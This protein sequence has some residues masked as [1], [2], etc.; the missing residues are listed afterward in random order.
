LG[1]IQLDE[2][3]LVACTALEIAVSPICGAGYPC[4]N[5]EL[6]AAISAAGGIG[7][8]QPLSLI[9]VHAFPGRIGYKLD[10]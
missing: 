2:P 5:P 4:A 9:Y 1:R 7:V 10:Q 8:V 3:C 6:V